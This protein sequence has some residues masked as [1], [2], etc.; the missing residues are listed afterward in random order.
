MARLLF[1][2]IGAT[3]FLHNNDADC[4]YICWNPW[5]LRVFLRSFYESHATNKQWQSV[6]YCPK[7]S[8]QFLRL[9][10]SITLVYYSV[11]FYRPQTLFK[12]YRSPLSI[13]HSILL[14]LLLL[15][16]QY[17]NI[18]ILLVGKG[19][20]TC[21]WQIYMLSSI[22]IICDLLLRLCMVVRMWA[23]PRLLG[24][25]FWRLVLWWPLLGIC[26]EGET[27]GKVL[28]EDCEFWPLSIAWTAWCWGFS[29]C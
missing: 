21:L 8:S 12:V 20:R 13:R 19:S 2:I 10:L 16:D 25:D 17:S 6:S 5:R 22:F 7:I 4:N 23:H 26:L 3:V 27:L 9:Q 28:S 11:G 18:F 1:K 29:V 15:K 14:L 24:H